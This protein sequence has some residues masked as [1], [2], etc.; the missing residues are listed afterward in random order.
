M[1][2]TRLSFIRYF[3]LENN[4][5][6]KTNWQILIILVFMMAACSFIGQAQ[7]IPAVTPSQIMP[8][9]EDLRDIRYCEILVVNRTLA[10]FEIDVYNTIG[11]SDCPSE[12]WNQIDTEALAKTYNAFT[13]ETNGPRY[14]V[15]NAVT[16][17]GETAAGKIVDLDGLEMKLIAEIEMKVWDALSKDSFYKEKEVQ[18][19]NT[20][21]FYAGNMVYELINPEGDVYRMQSYAQ[22]VDPALTIEDLASLGERLDLPE[23]WTYQPRLL[24]HDSEL[25]AD[26]LA[27]MIQDE[28]RNSYMKVIP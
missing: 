3:E 9:P 26:G 21:T 28:F 16:G 17:T 22:I 18:R 23:G 24:E 15:I 8:L 25:E 5:M 12:V 13:V 6:K 20:W 2:R 27:Y 11:S 1:F 4:I 10:T 19:S 14:W 7:V